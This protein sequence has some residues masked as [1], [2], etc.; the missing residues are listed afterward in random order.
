MWSEVL[1]HWIETAIGA[2]KE[3]AEQI[4]TTQR[5]L[6][7]LKTDV[8]WWANKSDVLN[9]DEVIWKRKFEIMNNIC[10][11]AIDNTGSIWRR[12]NRD[13]IMRIIGNLSED[14]L[15]NLY[16]QLRQTPRNRRLRV[17]SNSILITKSRLYLNQKDCFYLAAHWKSKSNILKENIVNVNQ[18][19]EVDNLTS[20]IERSIDNGEDPFISMWDNPFYAIAIPSGENFLWTS[21]DISSKVNENGIFILDDLNPEIKDRL[22]NLALY[23]FE[24]KLSD[25]IRDSQKD[26]IELY[27]SDDKFFDQFFKYYRIKFPTEYEELSQIA[28]LDLKRSLE[29]DYKVFLSNCFC[30]KYEDI[31]EDTQEKWRKREEEIQ[32]ENARIMQ[33][34]Q[35]I[36]E[37]LNHRLEKNIGDNTSLPEQTES[38]SLD[39]DEITWQEIAESM[40][41]SSALDGYVISTD[42][43]EIDDDGFR[44][45]AFNNA[46]KDFIED[47]QEI[48][49]IITKDDMDWYRI[50][51][52]ENKLINKDNRDKFCEESDSVRWMDG[53]ALDEIF[54]LLQ[55]N[56]TETYNSTIDELY[57][58]S[59]EAESKIWDYMKTSAIGSVIDD[60]REIFSTISE[61]FEGDLWSQWFK[62][63]NNEPVKIQWDN[64]VI[65]WE[66]NW[67]NVMVRYN[68]K[69]G[70]VY[71][72]S[73]LQ[74]KDNSKMILWNDSL[75]NFKI[76]ELK[77]FDDILSSH[78]SFHSQMT[79]LSDVIVENSEKQSAVNSIVIKFMKTFNII[80]NNQEI[81]DIEVSNWSDLFDFLQV[82]NN[83]NP[84]DLENFQIFMWKI[85][86]YA[87]LDWWKNNLLGPQENDKTGFEN[88]YISIIRDSISDFSNNPDIFK[89]KV[90]FDSSSMFWF[91]NMIVNKITDKETKPNRKLDST[92]MVKFIQHL[93]NDSKAISS[94]N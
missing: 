81:K 1:N 62:F 24:D 18:S 31:S 41:L 88:E 94:R 86:E 80:D 93:E 9:I 49:W 53:E 26:P 57:S 76:W 35:K 13:E 30:L 37:E 51:D 4:A 3:T 83:S 68:L 42:S 70:E 56:F 23:R 17:F 65:S 72:N 90:N 84:Y 15:N 36:N 45:Y 10:D 39:Y 19:F 14:E 85:L 50:F 43:H 28:G 11:L 79:L 82:I 78:D 67:A 38:C 20:I 12:I 5:M 89:D 21:L 47:H 52:K 2:D 69:S 34:A 54:H 87:W 22:R 7:D 40:N 16:D 91:A 48:A 73:F 75:S 6:D 25:Y 27:Y 33:Q 66:F 60:V 92:E 74:F 64:L 32:R 8:I 44:D 71:M 77:S 59:S 58:N 29:E 55:S 46:W 63:N 61:N